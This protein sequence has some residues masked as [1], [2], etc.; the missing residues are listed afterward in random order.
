MSASNAN[1]AAITSEATARTTATDAL[2]SRLDSIAANTG[3]NTAA[4][5]AEATARTNADAALA[6]QINTVAA[7]YGVDATNLCAN[8]VAAGGLDAG[9]GSATALGA[10]PAT[11]RSRRPRLTCFARTFATTPADQDGER[12]GQP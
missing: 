2:S 8:P 5:Q 12:L 1:T 11:C 6:T 10:P 3:T 7:A 9:W 4:V